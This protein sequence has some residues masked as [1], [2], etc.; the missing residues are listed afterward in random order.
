MIGLHYCASTG[1]SDGSRDAV[2]PAREEDL[3]SALR[4]TLSHRERV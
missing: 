3:H 2:R 4:A 1:F